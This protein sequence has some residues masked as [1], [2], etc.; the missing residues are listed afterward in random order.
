MRYSL[1]G[2]LDAV[3][4]EAD[5]RLTALERWQQRIIG[6]MMFAAL[7]FGSGGVGLVVELARTR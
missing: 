2:D 3:K 1:Q 4:T 5:L 7:I 6:G